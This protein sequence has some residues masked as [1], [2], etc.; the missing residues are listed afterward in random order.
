MTIISSQQTVVPEIVAE[1][2]A[3]LK[4]SGAKSVEIPCHLI[5]EIEGEEYAVQ[6]D[7][8]HLLA[9]A[10]ELGLSVEYTF[11]EDSEGLTGEKYLEA[12]YNDGDYYNVETSNPYYGHYDLT[13]Q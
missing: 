9:A 2:I 6:Y 5:G 1:K 8:H 13:W 12:R 11:E 3:E 10:R 7:H 4:E